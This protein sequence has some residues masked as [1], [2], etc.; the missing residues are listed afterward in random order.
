MK[1]LEV[2]V[3]QKEK[4]VW[5]TNQDAAISIGGGSSVFAIIKCPENIIELS[6]VGGSTIEIYGECKHLIVKKATAGS[7]LNLNSFF[8]EE[9]TIELADWGA[10]LELSVSRIIHSVCLKRA[11]ILVFSGSPQVSNINLYGGSVIEQ[12]DSD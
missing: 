10:C 3:G 2:S 7:H 1:T 11:S 6:I 9:A 5:D 12:R 8:C 4:I